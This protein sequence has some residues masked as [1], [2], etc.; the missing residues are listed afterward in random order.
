VMVHSKDGIDPARYRHHLEHL[1]K[2]AD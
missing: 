1:W 2:A